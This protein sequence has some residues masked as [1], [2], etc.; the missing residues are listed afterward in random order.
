MVLVLGVGLVTGWVKLRDQSIAELKDSMAAVDAYI[1]GAAN[2]W[3][4][5]GTRWIKNE[6]IIGPDNTGN[7]QE[8]WGPS[9]S[10]YQLASD[11]NGDHYYTPDATNTVV[12]KAPGG[13][14][15]EAP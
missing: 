5:G 6:T 12:Y 14:A 13:S 2:V 4:T 9:N 7:V 3:Q 10:N 8:L 1:Q 11:P 15:A